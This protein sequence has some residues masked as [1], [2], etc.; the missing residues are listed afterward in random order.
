MA[1]KLDKNLLA[2]KFFVFFIDTLVSVGAPQPFYNIN[3][4]CEHK[5][6]VAGPTMAAL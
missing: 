1:A 2:V 4:S 6:N 5:E 3:M